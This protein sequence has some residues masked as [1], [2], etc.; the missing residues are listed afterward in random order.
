[1]IIIA[2]LI[3]II[4]IPVRH[5]ELTYQVLSSLIFETPGTESLHFKCPAL[6]TLIFEMLG[7]QNLYVGWPAF[8][9]LIFEVPGIQNLNFT[10][11]AAGHKV[12]LLNFH[13]TIFNL[14]KCMSHTPYKDTHYAIIYV[15][16]PYF[17]STNCSI[18]TLLVTGNQ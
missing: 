5:L 6:A 13:A 10:C 7:I 8:A 11:P 12:T 9:A 17:R 18:N 16:C 14:K 2:M 1:M 3:M 15:F 4:K